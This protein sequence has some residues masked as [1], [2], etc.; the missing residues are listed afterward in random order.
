[1]FD[2][3]TPTGKADTDNTVFDCPDKKTDKV[4]RSIKDIDDLAWLGLFLYKEKGDKISLS[5]WIFLCLV[6]TVLIRVHLPDAAATPCLLVPY[7]IL[8]SWLLFLL[9]TIIL[10][11]S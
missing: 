11:L 6:D 7:F 4:L 5:P 10:I 1:M 8:P 2:Q 3:Q 9:F